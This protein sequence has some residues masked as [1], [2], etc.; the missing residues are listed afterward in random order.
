M[1]RLRL[2]IR[3]DI[4]PDTKLNELIFTFLKISICRLHTSLSCILYL[5]VFL[6][7][8]NYFPKSSKVF[9]L[10]TL[11]Y[12]SQLTKVSL[13]RNVWQFI[14]FNTLIFTVCQ[15]LG[16]TVNIG[17]TPTISSS[18]CLYAA[19]FEFGN[20]KPHQKLHQDRERPLRAVRY[21]AMFQTKWIFIAWP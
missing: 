5:V 11:F 7:H 9:K 10:E 2:L 16:K 12:L 6:A 20:T 8:T 14:I 18:S 15:I 4:R 13:N 21:Q 3:R 1:N 17:S 19:L